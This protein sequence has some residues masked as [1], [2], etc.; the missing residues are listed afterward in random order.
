MRRLLKTNMFPS[1]ATYSSPSK[2]EASDHKL[3]SDEF[4]ELGNGSLF[5]VYKQD[6]SVYDTTTMKPT[7]K[8]P[9]IKQIYLNRKIGVGPKDLEMRII[10]NRVSPNSDGDFTHLEEGTLEFDSAHTY[11]VVR[12]VYDMWR[13]TID[14]I[15]QEQEAGSGFG[16]THRVAVHF[17][18]DVTVHNS[19]TPRVKAEPVVNQW[20][21]G[22]LP[23]PEKIAC[24][25]TYLKA[26]N[27]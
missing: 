19:D 7:T 26:N 18:T 1:T 24:Q 21:S 20:L 10:R 16:L 23:S 3:W 2:L 12:Q 8:Q 9:L 6:P 25:V 15:M 13:G 17:N 22:Q 27:E 5:Y 14:S 4:L 11:A